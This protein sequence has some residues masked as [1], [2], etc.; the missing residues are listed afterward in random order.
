MS[1]VSQNLTQTSIIQP[2]ISA[3]CDDPNVTAPIPCMDEDW[4]H[5]NKVCLAGQGPLQYN[6]SKV[7]PNLCP[8]IG[9]QPNTYMFNSAPNVKCMYDISTFQ[10]AKDINKWV[11]T[12]GKDSNYNNTI[13]PSFCSL[14][15][16]IV[17]LIH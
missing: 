5:S 12:W 4:A 16:I 8:K 7:D 17:L 11:S 14:Q 6:C 1:I 3:P 2:Y 10:N 13:M 9:N 15:V